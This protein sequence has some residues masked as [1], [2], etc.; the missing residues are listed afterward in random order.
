MGKQRAGEMRGEERREGLMEGGRVGRDQCNLNR[1]GN[2]EFDSY[3]VIN[4][5]ICILM[6]GNVRER[7]IGTF[8]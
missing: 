5:R 3:D 8:L 2:P 7:G 4:C 1:V 6:E